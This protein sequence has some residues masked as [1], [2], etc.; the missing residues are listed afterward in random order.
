MLFPPSPAPA[1]YQKPPSLS[2]PC[3]RRKPQCILL[4][5]ARPRGAA[6]PP[7]HRPASRLRAAG[8]R[9]DGSGR[10]LRGGAGRHSPDDDIHDQEVAEEPHDADHGIEGHDGDGGDHGG[11]AARGRAGPA[12]ARAAIAAAARLGAV[13]AQRRRGVAPGRAGR[14]AG[15]GVGGE[16]DLQGAGEERRGPVSQQVGDSHG[17]LTATASARPPAPRAPGTPGAPR[18]CCR[19][20]GQATAPARPDGAP[21]RWLRAHVCGGRGGPGGGA[22]SAGAAGAASPRP[23]PAAAPPRP[24]GRGG[25][26]PQRRAGRACGGQRAARRRCSP[27]LRV[28]LEGKV[29]KMFLCPAPQASVANTR[30]REQGE[31]D[32]AR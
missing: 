26:R 32:L 25:G 14:A 20:V 30:K 24:A 9:P 23:P 13:P 28:A 7:G 31:T 19:G 29:A 16:R 4:R 2:L 5:A 17:C 21:R 6:S 18:C 12:A 1:L 27:P 3:A 15:G 11:A 8:F 22:V 10:G